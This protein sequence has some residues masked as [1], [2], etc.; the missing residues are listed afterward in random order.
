MR[1][2]VI[3]GVGDLARDLE[4]VAVRVKPDMRGVVNE[5]RKSAE[6]RARGFAR[7]KAGPHGKD[8][9]KRISSEMTGELAAEIGPSGVPKSNFVGAG[10]RHGVN[11]D[12]PRTADIVGPE[13]AA[14][15]RRKIGGWFW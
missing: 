1:V 15:V 6:M 9:H 2:R 12:L 7:E 11:T 5:S 14:G 10:F 8:Y 3:G 13:M 4:G